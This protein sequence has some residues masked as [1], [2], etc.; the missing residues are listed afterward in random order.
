MNGQTEGCDHRRIDRFLESDHV[1]LE[2]EQLLAHL[3][4]CSACRLYLETQAANQDSWT[5]AA[6]LLQAGEFDQAS[7]VEYSVATVGWSVVDRTMAIQSVIDSLAPSDDPRWLGRLGCYEV[8]GVIGAGGMG[9]VLK[10]VDPA[11][12]R[13][14]AIKALAPHL[15]N[16]GTARKRFLREAKA[17]AAVI[18]PNVISIH[19][20]AGHGQNPYLVMAYIRGGSLQK[21]LELEGPLRTVEILRIGSQV[22]GGLAAAHEQG[23][24]H[25]DVKPENILLEEG[26]ERVTLTDF[27]LA[28][29]VDDTS[30]TQPG[31]IAGTPQYMS[32]EQARGESVDHR[33]DLFSL[34]CVLY[35]LCTG[36]PPFRAETSYGVMRRII[37]ERAVP[38]REINP[39]IPDWLCE[40]IEKLMSKDKADR[41]QS[42]SQVHRLLEACL[43]H[44]QQPT[45]IGLPIELLTFG[46]VSDPG[47]PTEAQIA[48]RN[49]LLR[50]RLF[51]ESV[52][53]GDSEIRTRSSTLQFS[54]T[55][56]RILIMIAALTAAVLIGIASW[57]S[58]DPAGEARTAFTQAKSQLH[59]HNSTGD[60]TNSVGT[61]LSHPQGREYLLKLD[62]QF[63]H[64]TYDDRF[65]FDGESAGAVFIWN[66]NDAHAH[67]QMLIRSFRSSGKSQ[68]LTAE[69]PPQIHV[70][71]LKIEKN[72]LLIGYTASDRA[73]DQLTIETAFKLRPGA[74][75]ET[76]VEITTLLEGQMDWIEPFKNGR[77]AKGTN[78]HQKPFPWLIREADG[79]GP[80]SELAVEELLR[81]EEEGL[82]SSKQGTDLIDLILKYQADRERP[83]RT[84]LGDLIEER[85]VAGKLDRDLWEQYTARL[86]VDA[87]QLKVRPRIVIGSPGGVLVQKLIPDVRCGSGKHI[88]YL[89]REKNTVT[90]IG[91]TVVGRVDVPGTRP[92]G[93]DTGWKY[94]T[95]S[96]NFGVQLWE[97]IKPGKQKI[98]FEAELAILEA[99]GPEKMK[100]EDVF[101]SRRV[102]FET[103][104]TFLPPGQSTVNI[105]VDPAM[106][107]A[108]D[109]ALTIIRIETGPMSRPT[110]RN[111]FYAKVILAFKPRPIDTALTI[112]LKDGEN[113]YNAGSFAMKAED[114]SRSLNSMGSIAADLSGKRVDVIFRPA[115]EVAE[116]SVDIFEIW[117]GE[118]VFKDLL[119]R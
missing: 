21:R 79:R 112:V 95:N 29:A 16:N 27:G 44:V 11:L 71:E 59:P 6:K 73:E 30:V 52:T 46:E 109:R 2:D 41:F 35:A 47:R 49:A 39:E 1:G 61:L 48:E 37:D 110:T 81:R 104:T 111:K 87:Y 82:L 45:A 94:T 26:V 68:G 17:A 86:L 7:S 57:T 99:P 25:R 92:F 97:T 65:A 89:L 74:S 80:N 77:L 12:D 116:K 96:N 38:I 4:S 101:A 55:K 62:K 10:A 106:K 18:H 83:W 75:Y 42:A 13:V 60:P 70:R 53:P 118:I 119:V 34:G 28:R 15:A 107:A 114:E 51:R 56:T 105:N 108:V 8:S 67:S 5:N 72:R 93:N 20:V 102:T 31:T 54:T 100:R 78:L 64:F 66:R 3:D 103:E 43:S 63:K 33:S 69:L 9:V 19:S 24:V 50:R 36:R 85:W 84:E 115:P 22:A 76:T 91:S 40:V 58:H 23:L 14:V 117:G 88:A 113:E 98:T 90:K 32:P